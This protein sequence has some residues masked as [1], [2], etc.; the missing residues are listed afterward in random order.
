MYVWPDGRPDGMPDG[1]AMTPD[2]PD[3]RQNPQARQTRH[4]PIG[5]VWCLVGDGQTCPGQ[6]AAC[7][8]ALVE[9]TNG[10]GDQG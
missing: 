7:R 5:R 9:A 6:A 3:T 1:I 8:A 10:T 2:R 4:G